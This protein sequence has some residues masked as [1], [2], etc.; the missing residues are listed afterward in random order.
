MSKKIST[1]AGVRKAYTVAATG[2]QKV[3]IVEAEVPY[4]V[5]EEKEAARA[6]GQMVEAIGV[7]LDRSA[8]A[9]RRLDAKLGRADGR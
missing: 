2:F 6:I 1:S 7:N 5:S 3:G 8:A 4:S 9:I